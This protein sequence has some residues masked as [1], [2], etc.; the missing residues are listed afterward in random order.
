M[1]R[2]K[3][4]KG[5]KGVNGRPCNGSWFG[6]GPNPLTTWYIADHVDVNIV[7]S[8]LLTRTVYSHT[9][10]RYVG[11]CQAFKFGST[12]SQK[13]SFP[14]TLRFIHVVPSMKSMASC[15]KQC[16]NMRDSLLGR[17][18]ACLHMAS[19]RKQWLGCDRSADLERPHIPL[20]FAFEMGFANPPLLQSPLLSPHAL[21]L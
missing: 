17:S 5:L 1:Y 3:V 21:H 2:W 9:T 10:Y 7:N 15:R 11:L 13:N 4:L 12:R 6:V 19:C 18:W 16:V 14:A 8:S 20:D